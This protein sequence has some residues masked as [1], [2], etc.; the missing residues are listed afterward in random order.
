[1]V[2]VVDIADLKSA[3]LRACEFDS[4]W[5]HHYEIHICFVS[6]VPNPSLNLFTQTLDVKSVRSVR[7]NKQELM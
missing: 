6:C 1:M 4:R 5:G 3:A 2:E 7:L